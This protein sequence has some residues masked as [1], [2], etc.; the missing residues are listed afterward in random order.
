MELR[1]TLWFVVHLFL[2]PSLL[3]F[4]TF[5]HFW[6][7]HYSTLCC[8]HNRPNTI[9]ENSA[10]VWDKLGLQHAGQNK[11][12]LLEI[13]GNAST[14]QSNFYTHFTNYTLCYYYFIVVTCVK[15]ELDSED[16]WIVTVW[17]WLCSA[18]LLLR[19]MRILGFRVCKS[20]HHHTFKW[21]NQPDA[22]ISQVYCLSFK[23]SSTCFGHP[24]AHHQE[25]IK[26]SSS[27]WFTVGTW[28]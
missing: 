4:L 23:Y 1:V 25:L 17:L 11:H 24:H 27:L 10:E 8:R 9:M 2:F 22:A 7:P 13:S 15:R 20:L 19:N 18:T 16:T 6:C 14:L 5:H 28:W 26:C 3:P 12:Y 21:I